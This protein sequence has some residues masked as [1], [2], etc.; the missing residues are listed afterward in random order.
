MSKSEVIPSRTSKDNP[1]KQILFLL[2]W[3]LIKEKHIPFWS[4]YEKGQSGQMVIVNVFY[5]VGNF[6]HFLQIIYDFLPW[7]LSISRQL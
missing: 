3:K 6:V 1:W 7:V 4:L 2:V 5:Q